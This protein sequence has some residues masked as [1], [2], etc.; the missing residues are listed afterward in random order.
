MRTCFLQTMKLFWS[1]RTVDEFVKETG[2]NLVMLDE[3]PSMA[4]E[5][6]VWLA[7]VDHASSDTIL[8]LDNTNSRERERESRERLYC[9]E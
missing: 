6:E 8:E 7:I 9:I 1:R 2:T 5:D 4:V 3:E